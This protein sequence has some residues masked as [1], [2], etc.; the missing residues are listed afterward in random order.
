MKKLFAQICIFVA[1]GMSAQAAYEWV[2]GETITQEK[3][4]SSNSWVLTDDYT[5]TGKGDGPGSTNSDMWGKMVVSNAAGTIS[6]LEG[7][8]VDITLVNTQLTVEKLVK[9]Q[10][11][12]GSYFKLDI[13]KDSKLTINDFCTSS[14]AAG[15]AIKCD[16]VLDINLAR[17]VDVQ[18]TIALGTTGCINA[19]NNHGDTKYFNTPAE[20]TFSLPAADALI[21][22]TYTRTDYAGY[23]VVTRNLV[24]MDANTG[25]RDGMSVSLIDPD[26]IYTKVGSANELTK[27]AADIGKYYLTNANGVYS[28]SYVIAAVPEPATA[29]LSLLAL[30]AL[31]ARR[32]RK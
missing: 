17:W 5:W 22:G 2:G 24:T 15:F 26:G 20:L 32:R 7:W 3:W 25:I 27:S 31:A 12:N 30:A 29:T 19:R 11:N 23:S 16:G 28:V 1:L 4:N 21:P 13:D 18:G 14:I 8:Q 6:N 10:P 9:I